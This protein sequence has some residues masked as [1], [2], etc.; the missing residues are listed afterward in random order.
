MAEKEKATGGDGQKRSAARFSNNIKKDGHCQ[1]TLK[2]L[3]SGYGQYHSIN[4]PKFPRPYATTTL[5]AIRA[6]AEHP[7][8]TPKS[9]G[10]WVIFSDL[11]TRCHR[12]QLEKGRFYA[13]WSDVDQIDILTFDQA[14]SRT[15]VVLPHFFISYTTSGSTWFKQKFRLIVP[16]AI[17]IPGKFFVFCQRILNDKLESLG[18]EPDRASERPGQIC[19]LPN[20]GEFYRHHVNDGDL[21]HPEQ[22]RKEIRRHLQKPKPEKLKPKHPPTNN[23]TLIDRFNSLFGVESVLEKYRYQKRG[24]KWLSPNS[25]SKQ[26]GVTVDD[27]KWFSCHGNDAD[28]GRPTPAGTFGDAFDLFVYYEHN[29]NRIDAMK[30]AGQMIGGVA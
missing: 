22:W 23:G 10:Q 7:T 8:K 4:H 11:L 21:F 6:M 29:G 28:I 12:E 24:R 17:P 18:I 5:E 20:K 14:I 30:A 9:R 2:N 15:L 27:G 19:Y 1:V 16:L 13:L 26:P 25:E 3:C